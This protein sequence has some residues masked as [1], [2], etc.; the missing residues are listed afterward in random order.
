MFRRRAPNSRFVTEYT[1]RRLTWLASRMYQFQQTPLLVEQIQPSWL[2]NRRWRWLYMILTG[3]TVGIFAGILMWLLLQIL[4]QTTPQLG[5]AFAQRAATLFG[6]S[7]GQGDVLTLLLGNILLGLVLALI[8]GH[9]FEAVNTGLEEPTRSSRLYRRHLAIVALATWFLTLVLVSLNGEPLLALAW[10]TAEAFVFTITARY[11]YGL[12]YSGE[13]RTVEAL[14]W[15]WT[16]AL[17]GL[18]IGLAAAALF[19]VMEFLLFGAPDVT[20]SIL[21]PTVGGAVLGGMRGRRVEAKSRPNQGIHLSFRNSFIAGTLS[22]LILT[23]VAWYIRWP[24]YALYTGSLT[25]VAAGAL[26]GGGNVFKHF[27]VRT[28]LWLHRDLP[29]DVI[30]FLDHAAELVFLRKVGGG[31]IFIHRLLQQH[32]ASLH[33]SHLESGGNLAHHVEELKQIASESSN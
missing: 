16:S 17:R 9:Y 26:F 14:G 10:A 28:L 21:V 29:W 6:V 20:L 24:E 4:R 5:T 31:Y 1:I 33:E 13:I 8:Q 18:L 22:G 2:P 32:F 12:S 19:E 30:R 25:F 11:I 3:L 15:S 7:Q 23:A 27:L